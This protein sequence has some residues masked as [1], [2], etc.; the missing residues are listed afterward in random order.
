MTIVSKL[1]LDLSNIG[2]TIKKRRA[3][4][5]IKSGQGYNSYVL[6][7]N[8]TILKFEISSNKH[9]YTVKTLQPGQFVIY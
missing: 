2:L 4:N 3:I 6:R 5:L 7:A 1:S 8:G 9:G